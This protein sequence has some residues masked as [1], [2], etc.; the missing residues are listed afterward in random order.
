M[1]K[2]LP[3]NPQ[4][5]NIFTEEKNRIRREVDPWMDKLE[6]IGST[7]IPNMLA[8]STIDM[9][10]TV[11]N[12][13]I[14]DEYI[15]PKLESLGYRYLPFLE[16]AIP[17]RRYLQ[18]LDENGNHLFHIHIVTID[19]L[20]YKNYILFRDYLINHEQDTK[21]YVQFKQSLQKKF[22]MDREAY[23]EGKCLIITKILERAKIWKDQQ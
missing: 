20:R 6:H 17:D 21:E 11:E 14:A 12:L 1:I 3:Y 23:T 5:P 8:K 13:N 15:I 18:L 2:L 10:M 7:S 16:K 9:C 19:S 4:W 22:A